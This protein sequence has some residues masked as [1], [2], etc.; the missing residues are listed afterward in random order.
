MLCSPTLNHVRTELEYSSYLASLSYCSQLA[1]QQYF[2][3]SDLT[4]RIYNPPDSQIWRF[5]PYPSF[6]RTRSGSVNNRLDI[7]F[8][9]AFISR[10][11]SRCH[12]PWPLQV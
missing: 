5:E 1:V 7:L 2:V 3:P 10:H 12:A 4:R 6:V 9:E 8:A 11:K